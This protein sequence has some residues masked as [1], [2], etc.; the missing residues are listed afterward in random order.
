MKC[1]QAQT[2][3]NK[4]LLVVEDGPDL[5]RKLC[6]QSGFRYLHFE[7]VRSIGVKRNLANE[8]ALGSVICHWDDD[9]WSFP[10]RIAEQVGLLSG[11]PAVAVTG[12]HTMPFQDVNTGEIRVYKGEPGYSVGTSLCYR[13]DWWKAHPFGNLQVGEDNA[14]VAASKSRILTVDGMGKMVAR[15]HPKQTDGRPNFKLWASGTLDMIPEG[16]RL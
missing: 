13:R 15:C 16:A 12:Y 4:E 9:D 7:G 2:Y 3:P 6:Q 10:G 8:F 1:F 11:C 5:S 14:F